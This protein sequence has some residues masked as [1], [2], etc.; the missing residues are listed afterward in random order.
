LEIPATI[1]LKDSI[2]AQEKK[3]MKTH[4]NSTRQRRAKPGNAS[5][6]LKAFNSDLQWNQG[7]APSVEGADIQFENLIQRKADPSSSDVWHPHPIMAWCRDH[8]IG[9]LHFT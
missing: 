4:S 7:T 2:I 8:Q 3:N 6:P 1:L 9:S 5:E